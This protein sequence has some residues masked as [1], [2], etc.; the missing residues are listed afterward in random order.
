MIKLVI[1]GILLGIGCLLSLAAVLG[2]F[3]FRFV[4]NRMHAAAIVDAASLLFILTGLMVISADMNYIPKLLLVL[5][6][7]WIG[8]PIASHMV[9]R[10]EVEVDKSADKHMNQERI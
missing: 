10:L 7:Q 4:I 2:V 5:A 9:A 6:F 1:G 3:E 8:S